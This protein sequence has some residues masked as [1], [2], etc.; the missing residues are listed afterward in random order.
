MKQAI[1]MLDLIAGKSYTAI[2]EELKKNA[3]ALLPFIRTEGLLSRLSALGGGLHLPFPS[4]PY[5]VK[6]SQ[7]AAEFRAL[8]EPVYGGVSWNK[9]S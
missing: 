5:S 4:P 3:S 9:E 7:I 6:C 1:K 2:I 8:A